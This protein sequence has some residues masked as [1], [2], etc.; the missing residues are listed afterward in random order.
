[1]GALS[2]LSLFVKRYKEYPRRPMGIFLMDASKQASGALTIHILNM[3]FA[4]LFAHYF[5][6]DPCHFYWLNIVIDTTIGVGITY[7]I[8][9]LVKHFKPEVKDF[10]DYGNPP[11]W[12]LWIH[13]MMLWQG[14]VAT[15][16]ITVALLMFT[17]EPLLSYLTSI[18]LRPFEGHP[19]SEL[20]FVMII[21]P[22][23]MSTFQYWV[24]D[25][26]IKF[27][28]RPRPQAEEL[29]LKD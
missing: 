19:R 26:F 3:V 8:L 28:P 6:D 21:T 9:K 7:L 25:S 15:M 18:A 12:N 23:I 29:G 20:V 1:M 5:R 2:F 24:T 11:S 14:V 17:A 13:Q 22:T 27:K 10:G 16:K 4:S